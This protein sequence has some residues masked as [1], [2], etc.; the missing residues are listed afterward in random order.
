M[1]YLNILID[2]CLIVAIFQVSRRKRN[3]TR[4]FTRTFDLSKEAFGRIAAVEIKAK[5]AE[6]MA[7]RAFNMASSANLG[8]V[9]LQK[10]LQTP[11]LMT[12]EQVTRNQLVKNEVDKLFTKEGNF[13]WLRPILSDEENELLDEAEKQYEKSMNG[14]QTSE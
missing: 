6:K 4:F 8:V 7:D 3:F 11:R 10:A 14:D 13:D 1:T 2:L 5:V 12:K 9:A